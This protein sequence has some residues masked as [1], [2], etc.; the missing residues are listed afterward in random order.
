[1]RCYIKSKHDKLAIANAEVKR[2]KRMNKRQERALK[3]N[4]WACVMCR[5]AKTVCALSIKG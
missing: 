3:E 1:M 2:L 4:Y 5:L